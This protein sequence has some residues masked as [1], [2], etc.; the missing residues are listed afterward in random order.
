MSTCWN[1]KGLLVRRST[2]WITARSR[3]VIKMDEVSLRSYGI[4]LS[5][6]GPTYSHW[7]HTITVAEDS[8]TELSANGGVGIS[9]D[10]DPGPGS[11]CGRY[12]ISS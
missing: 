8:F 10:S 9:N 3:T 6:R 5:C 1:L 7:P 4:E 11:S 12:R 2:G